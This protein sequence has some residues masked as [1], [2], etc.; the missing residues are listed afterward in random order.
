MDRDQIPGLTHLASELGPIETASR[1]VR[2]LDRHAIQLF[3]RID[4]QAN[5]EREGLK[6]RPT[7]LLIFGNAQQGTGLMQLQQTC[8]IDL[9]LKVL[10]WQDEA[11]TT[12]VSYNQPSWV[13]ARHGIEEAAEAV[14]KTLTAGLESIAKAAAQ[15][16]KT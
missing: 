11:K 15:R 16:D 3:A 10:V 1:L 2:E 8:G 4:H 12:W 9:P 14:V 6:L 7:E 5:A 13:A